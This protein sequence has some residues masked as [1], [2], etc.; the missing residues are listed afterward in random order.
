MAE[1]VR[2]LNAAAAF[3]LDVAADLL[4]APGRGA[5]GWGAVIKVEA[6]ETRHQ[7]ILRTIR[8]MPQAEQD[9]LRG[10]V[11]WVQEYEMG[12]SSVPAARPE[13]VPQSPRRS[14]ENDLDLAPLDE[15]FNTYDDDAVSMALMSV[16]EAQG[17]RPRM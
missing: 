4:Q 12:A 7:A 16:E 5:G 15:D 14:P 9:R 3:R 11:D 6:G 8:A 17:A 1:V 10:L 13:S 2:T